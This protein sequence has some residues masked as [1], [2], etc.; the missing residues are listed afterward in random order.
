MR[1]VT[2]GNQ[3]LGL[4]VDNKVVDIRLFLQKSDIL[5]EE[6]TML[7]LIKN[8]HNIGSQLQYLK[9]PLEEA[10]EITSLSLLPPITNPSKIICIGDYD[11]SHT[12]TGTRENFP[13]P[14]FFL[15]PASALIGSG[16][17]VILPLEAQH[18][19]VSLKLAVII[20]RECHR[21]M[22]WEVQS[23][24]FGYTIFLDICAEDFQTVPCSW[25]LM[26]GWNT[27]GPIGPAIVTVDEVNDPL[28]LE[29]KV[30]INGQLKMHGNT[31]DMVFD[32]RQLIT[33]ASEIATLF[34]G[35]IIVAETIENVE[36]VLEGDIITA[37]IQELETLQVRV[38]RS[39]HRNLWHSEDLS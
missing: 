3:S 16:N 27:F 10:V 9:I 18:V 13:K 38:V 26:K 15:K 25:F 28:N 21:V 12:G 36:R 6:I 34:P 8:F 7:E 11:S 33:A 19:S 22:P 14:I 35:D 1:F 31:K 24:I 17:K 5:Q 30:M 37:E 39:L 29:M 2:Y 23:H 4:L 20:G 32:I